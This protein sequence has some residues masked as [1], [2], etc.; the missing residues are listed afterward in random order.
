MKPSPLALILDDSPVL[1]LQLQRFLLAAG[2][3]VRVCND[4]QTLCDQAAA[5]DVLFI[6]LQLGE[7][8]G[9]QCA[10][11][12]AGLHAC[13]VVL[14]TGSGR[15]TDTP[16]GWRAGASAV[17]QRPLEFS[18]MLATLRELGLVALSAGAA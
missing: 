3:A 12:I 7:G 14:I 11:Q 6:E 2:C 9:F 16:W 8:N 17:L 4:M 18:A 1:C 13:P 5:A 15:R 10:R